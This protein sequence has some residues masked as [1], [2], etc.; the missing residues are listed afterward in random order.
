[1]M[2]FG[3]QSPNDSRAD[4]HV[5]VI[6]GGLS[7]ER[8]VSLVTGAACADGLREAGYRV[9]ELDAGRDLPE[10]LIK[11]KPDV[12]FNAL[13][14]RYGEDGTI[15]GML[16]IMGIPYTHSGVLASALAMHKPQ[17]KTVMGAAGVPCP[18]GKVY[19][20]AEMI[21][22]HPIDPPYVMKPPA[23]G[24]SIGVVI[25]RPGDNRPHLN[26]NWPFGDEVLVEPFI[27]GRELT[28]GMIDGE[29]LAVTELRP[30]T[31]WFDY[32]AKYTAGMTEHLIPA[33]LPTEIYQQALELSAKAN[34]ALGCRGVTRADLRYD[35][36]GPGPGKLYVLEINTQP[37]MTPTSLVPEQAAYRGIGF[38]D[39]MARMVEAAQ[40]D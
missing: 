11:L 28:V 34:K 40:C 13:H 30:K 22:R 21:D 39:L 14:G 23:E 26:G 5:V 12:V 32:E 20:R 33:P 38:A 10:K 36:T 18:A 35:D 7:V 24:S 9:T 27:P 31:S 29:P 17:A 8:E 37:G 3:T 2:G 6:K 19:S 15:Q 16:D 4:R 1:M 25:V